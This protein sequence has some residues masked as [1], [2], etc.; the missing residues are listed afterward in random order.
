MFTNGLVIINK[1][2]NMNKKEN[3]I[4]GSGVLSGKMMLEGLLKIIN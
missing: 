4:F 2:Y 1:K 3:T